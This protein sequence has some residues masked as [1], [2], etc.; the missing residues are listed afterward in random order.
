M[1]IVSAASLGIT[2][3]SD[4]VIQKVFHLCAVILTGLIIWDTYKVQKRQ[5]RDA[6]SEW[7]RYAKNPVRRSYACTLLTFRLLPYMLGSRILPSKYARKFRISSGKILAEGLLRLGPL[8]IKIGQILSCRENLLPKEW[9]SALER[10]QDCVPSKSG[11]DA[12]ELAYESFGGKETFHK[13]L[14]HF[15]DV[16]LAAA[17]LGQVHKGVL[18]ETN[19]T[20]AIKLQRQ[21]L[22]LLYDKDL[23][24]MRKL[25]SSGDKF[26]SKISK[27]RSNQNYT[28]I[29][30]DAQN[31]LYKEIDYR[32][33]AQ[34][35]IRFADGFG[36]GFG[37][38]TV[39]LDNDKLPS[40]ASWLRVPL[41]YEKYSTEKL[42]IMEYVPSIKIN[43]RVALQ[44]AKV[45][46][47]DL[48][49]L[50]SSLARCYLRQF[51]SN[52]FF[53]TD[54]HPG[55]L[56]VEVFEDRPPR[57]VFYDFGQVCELKK[58][59]AEGILEVI[60]AIMDMNAKTC[61]DAFGKMGVLVDGANL[62][63]VQQKVQ[64]NFDSGRVT[65][66]LKKDV[67]INSLNNH[68]SSNKVKDSEVMKFFTLP[69]EYAFVA[70]AIS[71]MDGVGKGL[72]KNFDFISESAP[73]IVEV[74]GVT[75][76]LLESFLKKIDDA[77]KILEK[78]LKQ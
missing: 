41:V 40:A 29:F 56:G 22:R 4:N 57:L 2:S 20:V 76:F 8:Y 13:V 23:A 10:L 52:L 42:L 70:R 16:P 77:K 64:N 37:G 32:I 33:E 19:Q 34:N 25:A 53:S 74:K 72:N 45:S 27:N 55:N 49:F 51:C 7:G 44:E 60:E 54:P 12:V 14:S 35:T 6:T 46:D 38:K 75:N 43:N 59:Q 36:I 73:Y 3:K 47:E 24:L 71:Q 15:D 62:D 17:S 65:V 61:V 68:T 18:R 69:A 66:K 39:T 11:N 63:L 21:N 58:D 5:S 48:E 9:I 1:S 67:N 50:A 31:I 28:E 26:V 30:M 78:S